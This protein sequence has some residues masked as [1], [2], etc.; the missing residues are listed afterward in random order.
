MPPEGCRL[1][2]RRCPPQALPKTARRRRRRSPPQV[3]RPAVVAG[4]A[5]CS[6]GE[7]RSGGEGAV[8]GDLADP[9][10]RLMVMN[11]TRRF[12][13]Y[14]VQDAVV[15]CKFVHRRYTVEV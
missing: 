14:S 4:A 12:G 3:N 7:G 15:A 11:L 1:A 5:C 10:V 2:R 8:A 6:G 9:D 13:S